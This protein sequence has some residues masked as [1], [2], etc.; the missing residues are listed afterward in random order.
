MRVAGS[1]RTWFNRVSHSGASYARM[2]RFQQSNGA[3]AARPQLNAVDRKMPM[4]ETST[5]E[6]AAP[7]PQRADAQRNRALVLAAAHAVFASDGIA[8]SVD[9]IARRA[10]V[11]VGTIYRHFP[12]KQAL[13]EAIVRADLE[14]F[15][16]EGRALA[17][18]DE[19]GEALWNYLARLV[20]HS[21]TSAAI[22]DA[23]GGVYEVGRYA[24][25]AVHEIESA[26]ADLLARAQAAGEA[27]RDTSAGELLALLAAAYDAT[28]RPGTTV[29]RQHLVT[30]ICDG[31][32]TTPA[33]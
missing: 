17:S 7:K 11:G 25:D 6:R 2:E 23:L 9:L 33:S 29:S 5:P 21:E 24:G 1:A 12:T 19:P 3:S 15:A 4:I 18:S 31:M 14:V 8:V 20:N 30:V 16:A 26:V 27:R 10:G 32:R 22:K 13:F 28:A